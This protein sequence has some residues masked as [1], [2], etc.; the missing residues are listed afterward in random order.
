MILLD[1]LNETDKPLDPEG[2][3]LKENIIGGKYDVPQ[4][5][6][7]KA[8]DIFNHSSMNKEAK[9]KMFDLMVEVIAL[10]CTFKELNA[11][12]DEINKIH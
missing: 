3:E 5:K 4:A 12:E 11:L 10:K 8:K 9:E 7:K 1:L 6:L 2:D